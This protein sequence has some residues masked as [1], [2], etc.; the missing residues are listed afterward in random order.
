MIRFPA[1]HITIIY[2][3]KNTWKAQNY[4]AIRNFPVPLVPF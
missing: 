1:F 2:H 4:F 3:D